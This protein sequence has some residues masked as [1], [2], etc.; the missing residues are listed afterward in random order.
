MFDQKRNSNIAT[1]MVYNSALSSPEVTNNFI[2][3][4]SKFGL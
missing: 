2:A 1:C 4:K 3:L